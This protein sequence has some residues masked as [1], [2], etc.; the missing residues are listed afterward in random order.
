MRGRTGR[1]AFT[2]IELLVVMTIMLI[3]ASLLLVGIAAAQKYVR[4]AKTKTE[5]DRMIMALTEYF[6]EFDDYPPGGTDADD[7]GIPEIPGSGTPPAVPEHP[8]AFELQLRTIAWTLTVEGG[9]RT[10]GPY[11]SPNLVQ[12]RNGAIVDV[13]GTPLRYLADG[14][15][16]TPDPGTGRRTIGRIFKRGPVIWSLAEDTTQDAQ[17]DNV[18]NDDNG[19]VDDTPELTNDICSWN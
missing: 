5:I 12:V 11:Y 6:N 7:N 13:F 2:L 4:R 19:K 9:N 18:D 16:R 15:R 8:T 17:N 14:R 1:R 3:L 10:V